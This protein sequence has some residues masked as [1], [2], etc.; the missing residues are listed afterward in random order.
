MKSQP[1]RPS[2]CVVSMCVSTTIACLWMRAARA[3]GGSGAAFFDGACAFSAIVEIA[4]SSIR[5]GVMA[6]RFYPAQRPPNDQ[7]QRRPRDQ[8]RAEPDPLEEKPAE[9]G[10]AEQPDAPGQIVE[11]VR[12][13]ER[14]DAGR[15]RR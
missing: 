13:A 5:L 2:F 4:S 12:D 9:R 15:C 11:A 10:T 7:Q 14:S 6:V 3:A 8:Q 1:S